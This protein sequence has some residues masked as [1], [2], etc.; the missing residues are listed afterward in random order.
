MI[1]YDV[2]YR[3]INSNF[4]DFYSDR[5]YFNLGNGESGVFRQDFR[6]GVFKCIPYKPIDIRFV[7]SAGNRPKIE[8]I[9]LDGTKYLFANNDHD[10]WYVEKIVNSSNTDSVLFYSHFEKI[11]TKEYSDRQD[12]G[13]YRNMSLSRTYASI[14]GRP[15]PCD[16]YITELEM[17]G[18]DDISHDELWRWDEV[19]VID[20]IVGSNTAIWFG[21]IRDRQDVQIEPASQQLHSRLYN[22]QV[23]NKLS[24]QVIKNVSFLQGY[25]SDTPGYR[26]LMLTAIQTGTQRRRKI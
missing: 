11:L 5:F 18:P 16:N 8:M 19:V 13:A 22:I 23:F 26:R 2:L 21:Y 7:L 9:T 1:W 20:S 24:G 4:K 14:S 15:D 17:G 12:F 3:L 10:F 6:T 25:S